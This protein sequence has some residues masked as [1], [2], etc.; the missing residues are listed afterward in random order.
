MR[1]RL[2]H[3]VTIKERCIV[4]ILFVGEELNKMGVGEKKPIFILYET[5]IGSISYQKNIIGMEFNS[6]SYLYYGRLEY[7]LSGFPTSPMYFL[8]EKEEYWVHRLWGV[9]VDY[10]VADQVHSHPIIII[11]SDFYHESDIPSYFI[12]Y[13]S[14]DG[15][16]IIPPEEFIF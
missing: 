8:L 9:M 16:Y 11:S 4:K 15:V 6:D 10:S 1:R 14:G 3:L 5:S 2:K 7:L 13:Y 12:R